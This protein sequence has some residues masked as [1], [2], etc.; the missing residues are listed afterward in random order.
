MNRITDVLCRGRLI[1]MLSLMLAV[2]TSAASAARILVTAA[3]MSGDASGMLDTGLVALVW[4][5]GEAR[6]A[7][8]RAAFPSLDARAE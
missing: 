7:M 1:V 3:S 5:G 8:A 2:Q 6:S 4:H